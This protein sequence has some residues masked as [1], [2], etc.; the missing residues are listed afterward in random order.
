M[1]KVRVRCAAVEETVTDKKSR[2]GSK[3][4]LKQREKGLSGGD[5]ENGNSRGA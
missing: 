2:Q 3:L 5:K 1:Q 4:V